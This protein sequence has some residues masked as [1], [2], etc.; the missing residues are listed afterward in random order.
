MNR[1]QIIL[2]ILLSHTFN[3]LALKPIKFYEARPCDYNLIYKEVVFP[4]SDSVLLKG[5]FLP[6]QNRIDASS[7]EKEAIQN[8]GTRE[9]KLKDEVKRPTLI[10]CDGD[11][12]NMLYNIWLANAF[13]FND[14]NVF[15][16]DWRGFGESGDWPINEKNL[17]YTE[18]ISDYHA[19]IDFVIRQPE[20]DRNNISLFGYST[21]AYLSWI[22]ALQRSDVRKV[23]GRGLM[24]DFAD[25]FK[26]LSKIKDTSDIIIPQDFPVHL[27]PK[28]S[29]TSFNTPCFLIVGANDDRT[30]VWMSKEIYANLKTE[31]K[32]WIVNKALHGGSKAPEVLAEKQFFRRVRRFLVNPNDSM[33]NPR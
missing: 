8:K 32:L 26:E 23:I 20:V 24:T 3:S 10:I 1:Y 12:G 11:A 7:Q 14:F 28:Y 33:I 13:I 18:F 21:G 25:F 16:F 30:P 6:A 17:V 27:L 19:A 5:W 15:L 31:K 9:Y 4:T 22:V 2:F 29:A